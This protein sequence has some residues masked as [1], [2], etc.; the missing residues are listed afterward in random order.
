MSR[1][2][3]AGERILLFDTKGRRYLVQLV[4]GGEFHTHAG[5]VPHNDLIGREEGWVA[6]S[7][8]TTVLLFHVASSSDMEFDTTNLGM[9]FILAANPSGSST[10]GQ[11]A[12]NPW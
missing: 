5:P 9:E 10:E 8:R 2:F 12:A 3:E 6:R 4:E 7:T 11:A 1:L